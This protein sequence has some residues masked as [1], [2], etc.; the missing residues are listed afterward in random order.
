MKKL[1]IILI[2]LFA[3]YF[4]ILAAYVGFQRR[5]IYYPRPLN[6]TT[7]HQYGLN[8]YQE[9]S[10]PAS[11]GVTVTGW[12]IEHPGKDPQRPV[13]LYCHGNA[14][15]L[16]LLSEVSKIFYDFGFDALLIDYR[17]Y[18]NSQ[19]APL[20]EESVGRD[21]SSAY[22]WLRARGIPENRII[23]WGHS[24]GSSVAAKLATQAHPAGLILE[25]AFP[26]IQ[27]VARDKY[28]WLLILPFMIED[29]FDTEKYVA[30][31]ACPL[32]EFHA[33]RDTI[34]PIKMGEKVFEK[35]VGPKEW[36]VVKD[37][38]HNDFPSVAYQ[39][40]KIVMDFVKKCEAVG[41]AVP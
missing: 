6:G 17:G 1:R 28:P 15:N 16:S 31:R 10:F 37:T 18:G 13:L 9:V 21:A 40:K 22:Q 12:W 14:A 5:L 30:H 38:D 7:P 2:P 19:K 11:D 36:V 26:S 3:A 35:A 20:T 32:L 33:E 23:L 27:A 25:G 34:I 41:Q 39:Y 29:K 4:S 24:L 8:R